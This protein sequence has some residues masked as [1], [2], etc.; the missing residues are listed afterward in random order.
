[1]VTAEQLFGKKRN[2]YGN[3]QVIYDGIPFHSTKEGN[4]YLELKLLQRAGVIS[5]LELQKPYVIIHASEYGN[6]VKY[7]ADFVY[8]QDGRTVVEDSKGFRTKEYV[9]KKRLMAERF[10]IIIKET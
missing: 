5:N 2:K 9:I 10:G 6:D 8:E 4:R 7:I 1:M 3:K